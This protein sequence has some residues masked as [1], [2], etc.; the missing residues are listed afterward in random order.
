MGEHHVVIPDEFLVKAIGVRAGSLIACNG[1]GRGKGGDEV[2]VAA[3][4][5]SEKMQV[6]VDKMTK[7]QF[8]DLAYLRAC[9]LP[10]SGPLFSA[11]ASRTMMG[12]PFWLSRRKSMKPLPVFSKSSPSASRACLVSATVGS[13]RVL[14]GPLASA[15]T[16]QPGLSSRLLILMRAAASF[17]RQGGAMWRGREP[18]IR[19]ALQATAGDMTPHDGAERKPIP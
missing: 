9:S 14:A 13:S 7:R 16:R 15:K 4:Q 6:A 1:C 10:A 8:W 2:W 5:V 19:W 11:L 18:G 12:N 3:F 17:M